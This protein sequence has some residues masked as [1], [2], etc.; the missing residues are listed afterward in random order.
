MIYKTTSARQTLALGKKFAKKLR[1]GKVVAFYGDLGAGKTTFIKGIAAGFGIKKNIT[2]P[3]FVLMKV[4]SVR[5]RQLAVDRLV[6]IDCYRINRASE[7][8][9]VGADEY[10]NDE[11]AVVLIEWAEKIKKILP[12][13]TIKI[14][15]FFGEDINHRKIEIKK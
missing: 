9:A 14:N 11:K 15:F 7:I 5:S 6:H 2:S 4:Y 13:K 10:F 3:T 12:K 8:M 1:G